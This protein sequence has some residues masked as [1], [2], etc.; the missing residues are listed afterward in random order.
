APAGALAPHPVAFDRRRGDRLASWLMRTGL[1]FVF[2]YAAMSSFLHP[3]TFAGYFPSFL[4][5]SWAT[6]LLPVFAV[7]EVLLAAALCTRRLYRLAAVVAALTLGAITASN[8]D[9]FNVLFRN[10]AI[11]CAAL[12]LAAQTAAEPAPAAARSERGTR[13]R[14]LRALP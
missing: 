12:A 6:E 5:E 1:A 3:E 7:Y 10:V 4:P 14:R 8:P 13:T 2:L 11:A 9:A